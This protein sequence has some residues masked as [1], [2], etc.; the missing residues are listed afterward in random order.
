M[1]I[2]INIRPWTVIENS[3]TTHL[4]VP[5]F[6]HHEFRYDKIKHQLSTFWGISRVRES[7]NEYLRLVNPLGLPSTVKA[8]EEII[9]NSIH[10]DSELPFFKLIGIHNSKTDRVPYFNLDISESK[11][12]TRDGRQNHDPVIQSYTRSELIYDID[13]Y[14][15]EDYVLP[16]N[17][18]LKI[19]IVEFY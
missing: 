15:A 9:K 19:M 8:V 16:M 5:V 3:L 14:S 10:I 11:I 7:V 18:T 12:F 4:N 1:H 2:L 17:L 13:Q 6:Q